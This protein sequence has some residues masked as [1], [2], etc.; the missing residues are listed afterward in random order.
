MSGGGQDPQ[1][2]RH[3]YAWHASEIESARRD[4][5]ASFDLWVIVFY[6]SQEQFN[7]DERERLRYSAA[8]P[9]IYKAFEHTHGRTI[10]LYLCGEFICA[11]ALT[12]KHSGRD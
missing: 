8:L 4:Q 6:Y 2:P 1:T 11:T 10:K 5:F 7:Q 9:D 12:V 3:S